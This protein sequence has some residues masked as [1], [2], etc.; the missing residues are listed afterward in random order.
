MVGSVLVERM[1]AEKDFAQDFEATFFT[2]SN[3]GGKGP[4]VGKDSPPL[5]DAFRCVRQTCRWRG[6]G[7]KPRWANAIN[8]NR[9]SDRTSENTRKHARERRDMGSDGGEERKST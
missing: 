9:D 3:V 4:E 7:R 5:V 6:G 1:L 2:T 8:E